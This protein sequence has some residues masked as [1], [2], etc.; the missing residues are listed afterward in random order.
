MDVAPSLQ[1][2]IFDFDGVLTDNMV[3]VDQ[4]GRE[5]VRCSRGDGLALDAL[6]KTGIMLFI[7]STEKNPVIAA[8]GAKINVPVHQGVG[9]KPDALRT[10]AA[11][12]GFDLARTMYVGNDLNDYHAM[13]L[14]GFKACP[15]DSHPRIKD[16]ADIVLETA[17]GSGVVREIVEDV[18]RLDMLALLTSE[19][20]W[21]KSTIRTS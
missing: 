17:G 18:L 10:L 21:S 2:I 19:Q 6:R 16:M 9:S 14:C 11:D 20:P 13:L 15:R 5:S 7:L 8:R 4:D 12:Q 3:Y 1:C